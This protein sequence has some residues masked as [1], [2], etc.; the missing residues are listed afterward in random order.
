M[1]RWDRSL[2]PSILVTEAGRSNIAVDVQFSGLPDC[3]HCRMGVACQRLRGARRVE[4]K[5]SIRGGISAI[6]HLLPAS[7]STLMA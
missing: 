7:L 2:R 6:G 5:A 1:I 4:A 3:S